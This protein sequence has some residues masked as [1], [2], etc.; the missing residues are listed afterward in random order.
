VASVSFEK[1][2]ISKLISYLKVDDEGKIWYL[3]S[4]YVRFSQNVLQQYAKNPSDDRIDTDPIDLSDKLTV[5]RIVVS[6]YS[7][8]RRI[9]P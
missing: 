7:R 3:W 6:S 4:S 8:F 2:Q 5:F 1:Y 9:F